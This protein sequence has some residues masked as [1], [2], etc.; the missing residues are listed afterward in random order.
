[1]NDRLSTRRGFSGV[2]IL[3]VLSLMA[4]LASMSMPMLLVSMRRA[5]IHDAANAIMEVSS[6]ARRMAKRVTSGADYYG[7]VIWNQ[8]SPRYVA[9]T[10][11]NTATS[12]LVE[13]PESKRLINP[14]IIV[15]D[16]ANPLV[17]GSTNSKWMFQQRTALPIQNATAT[18]SPV[19]I[20]GL[21][22]QSLD[23]RLR[24]SVAI[25]SVGLVNVQDR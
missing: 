10:H 4:A 21:E 6:Q 16:G 12:T 14:N 24:S 13:L 22:L 3:I 18:A 8:T 20:L 19:S 1:M 15:F 25:Y 7:V 17:D 23:G 9:V 2:E 5:R 11:L